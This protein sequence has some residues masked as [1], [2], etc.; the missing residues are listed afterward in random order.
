[1]N[2]TLVYIILIIV[3]SSCSSAKDI[4]N[5]NADSLQN[6]T[7]ATNTTVTMK[8]SFDISGRTRLFI[9]SLK[10]E[11][12]ASKTSMS[13]FTPSEKLIE[14][15]SIRKMNTGYTVSGFIKTTDD[16]SKTQ[17]DGTNVSVGQ[18]SGDIRTIHIPLTYFP[19]FLKQK[20][21]SYF[22]ISKKLTQYK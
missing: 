21:I 16:F 19:D 15:Y 8:P 10:Q 18:P 22:E 4:I 5:N 1:M 11:I 12:D 9:N 13:N 3:L 6:T 17:F 20:N 2:R 14:D 7:N